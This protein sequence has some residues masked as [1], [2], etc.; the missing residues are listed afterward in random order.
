M[1]VVFSDKVF[2][3]MLLVRKE[4]L[5]VNS[6]FSVL[7]IWKDEI[8]LNRDGQDHRGS[9]FKRGQE[10]ISNMLNLKCP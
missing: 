3:I 4:E 8:A 7:R 2:A 9:R 1:L 10:I 5:T 6:R